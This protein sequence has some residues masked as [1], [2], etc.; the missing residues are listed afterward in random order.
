MYATR[1]T[2]LIVG[3]FALLGIAAL[4]FLSFRL[5]KVELIAPP[6]YELFAKFDNVSGLKDGDTVE[7]AGVPV[8]KVINIDLGDERANVS[9]RIN[10]GVKVDN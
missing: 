6:S 10:D 4:A 3:I 8:G 7:I 1:T 9:M 5:G 2:Q